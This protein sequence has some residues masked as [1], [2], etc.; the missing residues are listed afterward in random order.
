MCGLVTIF[1][2]KDSSSLVDETELNNIRESMI[3]RGPDG[4]GTWISEDRRVGLAHRRLAIIDPGPSGAQPM[5]LRDEKGKERLQIIYNGEIYNFRQIRKDLIAQGCRFRTN[6][7]T[8]VLLHLYDLYGVDML[9]RLRGMFAFA[10]WDRDKQGLLLA[11]DPYGIKPLYYNDDGTTLRAASTVKAL[12]AGNRIS[13]TPNA[14]AH[15]GFLTLGYVPEPHTLYTEIKCVPAGN[16]LWV[17]KDGRKNQ[18]KYF[19]FRKKMLELENTPQKKS[20]AQLHS[21][22]IETAKCHLIADVPV[23]LFLSAGLDSASI[24][25]LAAEVSNSQL[26][27]VTLRFEEYKDTCFDEAPLANKI[28][29]IYGTDHETRKITATDFRSQKNN[30]I[31]AM[32][33]P[34]IDG[35]NT[36]FIAKE[37]SNTGLKAAISGVGGDELFAGYGSFRQI[38]ALVSGLGWIPFIGKI[39]VAFR[40]VS[41]PIL[42]RFTS[43]KYASFFE[44]SS[45]YG[46]AYLLRRGLFLPWELTH[47]MDPEFVQKGWSELDL[48]NGLNQTIV[49]VKNSINRV[50]LMESAWYMRNQLLRDA[51]WAGMAHSIEIRTPLVDAALFEKVAARGYMKSDMA[52]SPA[53]P[54][55][56]NII[57]RK[58]TGF[59]TPVS[60]WMENEDVNLN[61]DPGYRGW[62]K[63]VYN[64]FQKV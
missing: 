45:D 41:G 7:D 49:G 62:A 36:Y 53:K 51:D 50:T 31:E 59:M 6:S 29:S 13:K 12:L 24:M 11:R 32:D 28:S 5:A 20:A 42:K 15:V 48:R 43:A 26:K 34:T 35:V 46:S 17:S 25:A 10:V 23:G 33:Q 60:E 18:E 16:F 64:Q 52:F 38:P 56:L 21:A 27:T 47:F 1:S 30:L 8:E 37:T 9:N 40:I 44:Y 39:G 58:K 22:L 3:N 61:S 2:Y 14:A 57:N 63:Y 55:P 54:L 4:A 19:D